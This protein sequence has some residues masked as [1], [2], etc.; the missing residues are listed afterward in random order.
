MKHNPLQLAIANESSLSHNVAVV[1]SVEIT[2][3]DLNE[4]N[5]I[6][7]YKKINQLYKKA[8][9]DDKVCIKIFC[10][11]C[12]TLH[13]QILISTIKKWGYYPK[14]LGLDMFIKALLKFNMAV[15][16]SEKSENGVKADKLLLTRSSE[17]RDT[18]RLYEMLYDQAKTCN[19]VFDPLGMFSQQLFNTC[20]CN[21]VS[22]AMIIL[23]QYV[24]S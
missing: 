19:E 11:Q 4:T 17:D 2:E 23:R 8:D 15:K 12:Q 22:V 10:S 1:S 16:I 24:N 6:N 9:K 3:D 14:E 21:N 5:L 13:F 18:V 7:A 20:A